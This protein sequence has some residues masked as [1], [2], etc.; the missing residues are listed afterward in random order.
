M[1][2]LLILGCAF[3]M[4]H[5]RAHRHGLH[6]VQYYST[7]DGQSLWMIRDLDGTEYRFL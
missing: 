6:P 1:L 7:N 4:Q 3:V 5:P 2:M